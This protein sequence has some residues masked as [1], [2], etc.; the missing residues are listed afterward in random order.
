VNLLLNRASQWLDVDSYLPYEGRAVIHNKTTKT[1]FLRI[2]AWADK[3]TVRCR[4]NNKPVDLSWDGN[5]IV[6]TGLCKKDTIT[7]EFPMVKWTE[8]HYGYTINFKGNTV[9]DI[10]PRGN[11]PARFKSNYP[12]YLRD[13]MKRNKA[14]MKEITRY[15]APMTLKW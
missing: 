10:S 3:Q 2:P 8:Q 5:H 15:V 11:L 7:A 13:H 6:I 4:L 1:L 9:V 12:I 14:P